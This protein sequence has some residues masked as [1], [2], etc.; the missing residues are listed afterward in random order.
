[1]QDL[2][3]IRVADAAE[4]TRIGQRALQR[5]VLASERH[6]EDLE[7]DAEHFDPARIVSRERVAAGDDV[8]RC[9]ARRAS[10]GEQQRGV[11]EIERGEAQTRGNLHARLLPLKT[12]GDHE[13]DHEIQIA[14]ESPDEPLAE[15]GELEDGAADGRVGTWVD[16]SDQKR[17]GDPDAFESTA[18][19]PWPQGVQVQ[20]D[21]RQFW[22]KALS[23]RL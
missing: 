14:L 17:I 21:V 2:I 8:Q 22:H 15:P 20:L 3:R 9:A 13:V 16:R 1:M 18:K 11:S 6:V 7:S 10:F 19:Q 4:E 12:A 5:V 23:S